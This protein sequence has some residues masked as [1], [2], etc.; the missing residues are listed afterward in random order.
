LE[1]TFLRRD[2][3]KHGNYIGLAAAGFAAGAVNGLFGGGGGMVLVPLLGLIARSEDRTVFSSSI[4]IILPISVISLI[5]TTFYT[6][7]P[8][9]DAFPWLFGSAAGGYLAT[10]WGKKIPVLWLHRGL[11]I[12]IIYGGLR[13]LC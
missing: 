10:K 2:Y 6:S 4:A 11:G 8:W 12:L 1:N 5:A 9:S 7:I 13:N 3:M